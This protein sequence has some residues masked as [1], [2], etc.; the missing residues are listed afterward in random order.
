MEY[1]LYLWPSFVPV[2]FGHNP[3]KVDNDA[4]LLKHLGIALALSPVAEVM[5]T[6][7]KEPPLWSNGWG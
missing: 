3:T 6:I 4:E 2:D 5:I 7:S 1:P